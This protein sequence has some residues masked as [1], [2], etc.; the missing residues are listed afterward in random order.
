MRQQ[1]TLIQLMRRM[2]LSVLLLLSLVPLYGNRWTILVYMAADNNLSENGYED[3][4]SMESVALPSGVNVIVQADFASSSPQSGGYRYRIRQDNSPMVTSPI[5]STLGE[6]NSADPQIM[7]DFIR[8]GFNAYPA[9]HKM[10]VIWS[11]G[12]SWY[13]SD[14]GKWICP[15]ES[16]QQLMSV[17]NGDLNRALLNIP[18]LDILLFDAC[19]MQTIE[20]L[21]EVA[22]FADYVIGSEDTVP[23][24][25]FPYQ[26]ILPLFNQPVTDIVTQI[27]LRYT[28]S[29]DAFGCQNPDQCGLAV[30]CSSIRTDRLNAFVNAWSSFSHTFRDDAQ[31]L[32]AIREQCFD[33]NAMYAEIDL[34][35]FLS[36][37]AVNP[38]NGE[39]RSAAGLLSDLWMDCVVAYSW[40]ENTHPIGTAAVWFP[41][42]R[43]YFDD[44]WAH[45]WRLDFARR[46]N[47][48]SLINLAYGT[49]LTPPLMPVIDRINVVLSTLYLEFSQPADPD[50]LTYQITLRTGGDEWHQTATPAKNQRSIL[51]TFGVDQSGQIEIRAQ[52]PAGN[53]SEV[54]V[55]SYQYDIP[56]ATMIVAPNP[57]LDPQIATLKWFTELAEP[58]SATLA[59]Y[60]IRGRKVLVRSLGLVTSGE[61]MY[62]LGAD[63]AFR[64][65]ASGHYV[66]E[67]RL[68]KRRITSGFTIIK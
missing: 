37:A 17:A 6:I 32:L 60:D 8:W 64:T 59:V 2:A 57:I 36:R 56:P 40:L 34:R 61:S 49:D 35:E 65:L 19:G 47:W 4:N 44:W 11:H 25:G 20:V 26:T 15:D 33:M 48:L 9:Q 41:Q 55:A 68:G 21:T 53:W 22:G 14:R 7:N 54:N 28:E 51:V 50:S 1:T 27:P 13:K 31:T 12:S 23:A 62:F 42:Y 39:L 30:T 67:L 52:D 5:L 58:V 29:Y 43:I 66:A 24:E 46:T 63:P 38:W 10:L 45:Y 16:S 18:H 3:I